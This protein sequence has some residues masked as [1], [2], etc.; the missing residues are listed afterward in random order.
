MLLA[1]MLARLL[2][3]AF[4]PLIDTSEARYAGIAQ[5]IL[6][7]GDWIMP[8]FA[9]GVPFWGKP[10]LAFWASA[11]SMEAFGQTAF[12]ARLPHWLMAAALLWYVWRLA[13]R[14]C[15]GRE[16]FAAG[17]VASAVLFIV[18]AGSVVT[19]MAL[20]LCLTLAMG[21]G[22]NALHGPREKQRLQGYAAFAALGVG[23]L[24]KGPLILVL[25]G[26]SLGLWCLYTRQFAQVWRGLPWISGTLLMLAIAL[27]WYLIAEAHSP[28][29]LR[30]FIVG[31]HWQRFVTPG[32]QGDLYGRGHKYPRGFIW[33]FAVL[34]ALPWSLLLPLLAWRSYR[35]SFEKAAQPGFRAYLMCWVLAP[36]LLFTFAGNILWSYALPALPALAL[37]AASAMRA[38]RAEARVLAASLAAMLLLL[39]AFMG[40]MASPA[41]AARHSA[42]PLIAYYQSLH[43]PNLKLVFLQE[44]PF[45]AGFYLHQSPSVAA[46]LPQL[47]GQVP[48]L[49]VVRGDFPTWIPPALQARLTPEAQIGPYRLYRL[50]LAEVT[51]IQT[52]D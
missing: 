30:Y 1:L 5:R 27:P 15:P 28:G 2:S 40:Y 35:F 51:H 45:S 19:D 41:R 49:L 9:P 38:S 4:Y 48:A 39:A 12:A 25:C 34:S 16:V 21:C 18:T 17:I 3:L 42:Q 20:A 33:L 44:P 23:L 11:L 50:S 47:E 31:E 32:W 6:T 29:F 24:A 7:S 13:A 46:S 8:Q 22:W 10:P 14:W 43:E 26:L 37:L 52:A 36:C